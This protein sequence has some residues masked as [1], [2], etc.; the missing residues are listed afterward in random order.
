MTKNPLVNAL[1][2]SGYVVLVVV[3]I[4]NIGRIQPE[5]NFLMPIGFLSVLVLSVAF[6]AYTFF[7]Q[8]LLLFLDGKRD[9]AVR[10]FVHTLAIYFVFTLAVLIA[11][12]VLF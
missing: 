10:L 2:A 8:P 12:F 3:G 9:A 7:Y 11:S 6:M 4:S 5:D 1:V